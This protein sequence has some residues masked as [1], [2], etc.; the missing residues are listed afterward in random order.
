M[1]GLVGAKT[2]K[3]LFESFKIGDIVLVVRGTHKG[4]VGEIAY[5]FPKDH[6]LRWVV[7]IRKAERFKLTPARI[8]DI[9]LIE[10]RT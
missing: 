4:Q 8:G 7:R 9:E 3:A 2:W 5:V 10:E 6:S 1:E